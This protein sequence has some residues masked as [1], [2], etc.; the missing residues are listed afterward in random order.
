M[1]LPFPRFLPFGALAQF[2]ILCHWCRKPLPTQLWARQL[3]EPVPEY[4]NHF[5]IVLHLCYI[6]I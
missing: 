2:T 1:F 3:K 6:Q 5:G 4:C